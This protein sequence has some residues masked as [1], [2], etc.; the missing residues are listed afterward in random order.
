MQRSRAAI[1]LFPSDNQK[2]SGPLLDR[3]LEAIQYHALDRK[4][5]A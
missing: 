4:L 5:F 1:R 2:I 3:I